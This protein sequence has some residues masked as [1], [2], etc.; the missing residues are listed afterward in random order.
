[1]KSLHEMKFVDIQ[2]A[3]PIG[4]FNTELVPN[5]DKGDKDSAR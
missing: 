1:M 5:L 4:S 2:H 3:Q